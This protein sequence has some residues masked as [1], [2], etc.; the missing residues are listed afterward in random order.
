[1]FQANLRDLTVVGLRRTDI[2]F[3]FKFYVKNTDCNIYL[4]H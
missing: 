2:K 4:P 1:M 3:E